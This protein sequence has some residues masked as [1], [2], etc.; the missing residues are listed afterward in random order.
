MKRG[1]SCVG[2]HTSSILRMS[3]GGRDKRI[4]SKISEGN[5]DKE[6]GSISDLAYGEV[7]WC[8]CPS[9]E[10]RAFDVQWSGATRASS[11]K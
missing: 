10:S 9:R 3:A 4:Y 7:Q 8:G 11:H 6:R 2:T 5:S 1:M